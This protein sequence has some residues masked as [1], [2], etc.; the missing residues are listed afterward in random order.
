MIRLP[1]SV[2]D[3]KNKFEEN[4]AIKDKIENPRQIV[5]DTPADL[6]FEYA[7]PQVF[8]LCQKK[9]TEYN[10]VAL[11]LRCS[12]MSCSP[13][14]NA[15]T[16]SVAGALNS[17]ASGLKNFP[18]V[19]DGFF[20]KNTFGNFPVAQ[21]IPQCLMEADKARENLEN[22][23]KDVGKLLKSDDS[24]IISTLL[25]SIFSKTKLIDDIITGGLDSDAAKEIKALQTL[26]D[27]FKLV[28]NTT[29]AI[30]FPLFDKVNV[31][32]NK[33][34]IGKDM[35]KIRQ[36]YDC[37][38]SNCVPNLPYLVDISDVMPNLIPTI[39]IDPYSGEFRPYKLSMY[40]KEYPDL[41][42]ADGMKIL[43]KMDSDYMLY[44]EQ[45][46]NKAQEISEKTNTSINISNWI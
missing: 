27:T 44:K 7:N 8:A 36:Y 37:L 4:N 17:Y 26:N 29:Q 13:L 15:V 30:L 42:S 32:I 1:Q 10:L 40:Q 28:L 38:N 33:S 2:V 11:K 18:E 12:I 20:D 45:R 19:H 24:S 3:A 5:K 35:V 34:Q 39:P 43:M 23:T 21:G 9:M 25:S 46:A 6:L 31:F 16:K 14:I 22:V 41:G